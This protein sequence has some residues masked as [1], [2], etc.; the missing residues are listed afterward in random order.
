MGG[1]SGRKWQSWPHLASNTAVNYWTFV[2]RKAGVRRGYNAERSKRKTMCTKRSLNKSRPHNK[3]E[4]PKNN[5]HQNVNVHS[6]PTAPAGISEARS[7]VTYK[8]WSYSGGCNV[9]LS[10]PADNIHHAGWAK[11]SLKFSLLRSD[12][13]L[14]STSLDFFF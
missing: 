13:F 9:K 7:F 11:P 2:S 6:E 14:F 12:R 4:L 8:A 10:L 1:K 5:S 3:Q